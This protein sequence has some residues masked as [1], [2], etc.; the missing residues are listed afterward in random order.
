MKALRISLAIT[1]FSRHTL[2]GASGSMKKMYSKKGESITSTTSFF[3]FS[4]GII[5]TSVEYLNLFLFD[6]HFTSIAR[7][8]QL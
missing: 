5:Q 8:Y 7:R 4:H 3:A 6:T 2:I 1:E